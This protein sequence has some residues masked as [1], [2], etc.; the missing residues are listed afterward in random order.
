MKHQIQQLI[1]QALVQI[2][3]DGAVNLKQNPAGYPHEK[4][5]IV[6]P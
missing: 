5:Q 6:V 4:S 2:A 1:S 3:A